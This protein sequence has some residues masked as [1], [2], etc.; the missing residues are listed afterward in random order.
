MKRDG[1]L[2]IKQKNDD[3]D[4]E[5]VKVIFDESTP[6]PKLVYQILKTKYI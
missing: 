5:Q 2:W 1:Y 4:A 6:G 3:D